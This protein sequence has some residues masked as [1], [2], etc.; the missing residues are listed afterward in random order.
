MMKKIIYAVTVLLPSIVFAQME[1]FSP[2]FYS[3]NGIDSIYVS[4]DLLNSP[5]DKS[6]CL[7]DKFFFDKDGRTTKNIVFINCK[8]VDVI[9][10]FVLQEG[11]NHYIGSTETVGK[12]KYETIALKNNNKKGVY[13]YTLKEHYNTTT[14]Y[15]AEYDKKGQ[16]IK[17]TQTDAKKKGNLFSTEYSYNEKGL[18]YSI[19]E[20]VG[21]NKITKSFKIEFNNEGKIVSMVRNV[22]LNATTTYS[23]TYKSDNLIMVDVDNKIEGRKPMKYKYELKLFKH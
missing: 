6:M 12:D 11:A 7:N 23:Y 10:E 8:T 18:L 3:S 2:K 22:G 1:A 5:G 21:S 16:L 14:D 19:V 9:K 13:K 4:T 20:M 15:T 17:T